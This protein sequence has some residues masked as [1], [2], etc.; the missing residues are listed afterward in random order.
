MNKIRYLQFVGSWWWLAL[1]FVLAALTLD[2]RSL[3]GLPF[4]T[5]GALYVALNTFVVED[6]LDLD[7]YAEWQQS[8]K[9]P[10][11]RRWLV[12]TFLV[13]VLVC[14]VAIIVYRMRGGALLP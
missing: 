10:V 3:L 5:I 9:G 11:V 4:L 8:R 7:K 14:V 1:W 13:L 6:E 12:W 2:R